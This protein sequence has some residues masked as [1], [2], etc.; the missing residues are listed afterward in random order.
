MLKAP[1]HCQ[2]VLVNIIF[3]CL[4]TFWAQT[5]LGRRQIRFTLSKEGKSAQSSGLLCACHKG[6]HQLHSQIFKG[7][8]NKGYLKSF[9]TH[10][11]TQVNPKWKF[12]T[13]I[14]RE[15]YLGTELP[16][17]QSQWGSSPRPDRLPAQEGIKA[18]VHSRG[19]LCRLALHLR[20]PEAAQGASSKPTVL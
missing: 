9:P 1:V 20:V 19:N 6:N 15:C 5:S 7:F 18:L 2:L 12:S 14:P 16:S 11:E 4:F 13:L 8:P 3:K 17:L 10:K